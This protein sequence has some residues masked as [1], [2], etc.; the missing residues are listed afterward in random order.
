MQFN[1]SFDSWQIGSLT[2]LTLLVIAATVTEV[3]Q[4]RIPGSLIVFAL[5]AGFLL[6]VLGPQAGV[7]SG[8][9]F[10]SYP[11]ALGVEG[12]LLGAL[13][14]LALFFP[15]YLINALDESDVKLLAGIGSF[16]GPVALLNLTLFILL[17]GGLLTLVRMG[18][19]IHTRKGFYK[20]GAVLLTRFHSATQQDDPAFR[21]ADRM[22]YA[23][24]MAA[25]MLAYGVW[26][27]AG[28]APP[29]RF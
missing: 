6:N 10:T 15:L 16:V 29:I 24:A 19:K 3:R 2:V 12:A 27:L 14:G 26:L 22:P 5:G 20:L 13:M 18:W 25:G 1:M 23:V 8:G 21:S 28:C 7:R 9:L 11:G 17:M 4:R